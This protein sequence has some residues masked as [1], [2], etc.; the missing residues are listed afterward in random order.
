LRSVKSAD[1]ILRRLTFSLCRERSN[2]TRRPIAKPLYVLGRELEIAKHFTS[3]CPKRLN[4]TAPPHHL[5]TGR[6]DD[7]IVYIVCRHAREIARV[8]RSREILVQA[9]DGRLVLR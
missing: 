9:L 3:A 2:L 5:S 1:N 6:K 8:E 4:G 7:S